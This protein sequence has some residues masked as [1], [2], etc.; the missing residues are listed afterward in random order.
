[1]GM[2]VY[3][4]LDT[5]I[6][7]ST[8]EISYLSYASGWLEPLADRIADNWSNVLTPIIEVINDETLEYKT[9]KAKDVQV[10]GFNW[11]LVFTWH[12][13]PKE[14]L[15]NRSSSVAPIK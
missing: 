1:M 4:D 2:R 11:N 7:S 8:Y 9:S 12:V 3:V 15:K 14:D 13:I 6:Y 10:G 5:V